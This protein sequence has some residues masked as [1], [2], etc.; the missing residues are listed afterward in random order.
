MNKIKRYHVDVAWGGYE[1]EEQAIIEASDGYCCKSSDV[2]ALEEK[3]EEA[4]EII[5]LMKEYGKY[6]AYD[7]ECLCQFCLAERFLTTIKEQK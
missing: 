6:H 2:S 3:L 1:K 7:G 4:V 5:T